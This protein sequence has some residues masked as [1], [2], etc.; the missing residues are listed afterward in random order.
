MLKT[1]ILS[2]V[3]HVLMDQASGGDDGASSAG[4]SA[5]A[6]GGDGQQQQQQQQNQQS[7]QGGDGAQAKPNAAASGDDGQQQQQQQQQGGKGDGQQQQQQQQQSQAPEKYELKLA[8]DSLLDTFTVGKVEALARER[9]L[10]NE[11]A[12]ELLGNAEKNAT[13]ARDARS[14]AWSQ[15]WQSDRELGGVNMA[16][17]IANVDRFKTNMPD[18]AQLLDQTGYMNNP[19]VMRRLNQIGAAMSEDKPGQFNAT[20]GSAGPKDAATVLYG[21]GKG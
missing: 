5:A 3:W 7:G 16:R 19:V 17:T 12:Q 20:G 2:A 14:K 15:E 9:G 1:K 11:Q 18:L 10:S 8:E 13:E 4:G 21:G 6:S